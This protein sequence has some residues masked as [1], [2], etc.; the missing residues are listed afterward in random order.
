M[1]GKETKTREGNGT[2]AVEF[3]DM[4]SCKGEQGPERKAE[5]RLVT[6]V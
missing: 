4:M 5:S 6:V 1:G 3:R 2:I